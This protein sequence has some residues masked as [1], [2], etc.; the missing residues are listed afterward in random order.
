MRAVVIAEPGGPEKLELREVPSPS[1]YPGAVRVA[2]RT[3]ALNRADVLQRRGFYP[4]PPGVPADIPGLEFAGEVVECGPDARR[5]AVG[6]RVMGLV[7]GGAHAEEVV[8]HERELLAVP[9]VLDDVAAAAVPEAFIT[10]WDALFGQAALRRGETVLIHAVGSGVGT[11]A[12]Q[13]A[14]LCGATSIGTSRTATKLDRAQALGLDHG[15]VCAA[16]VFDDRSVEI[17]RSLSDGRGVDV[18]LDLVGGRYLQ[19]NVRAMAHGARLVTLG[20]LSGARGELDLS[21]VLAR[22][23]RLQGSTLRGRPIEQK[24]QLARDFEREVLPAFATGQL[25]PVVERVVSME[26]VREAHALMERNETFGKIVLR[27]SVTDRDTA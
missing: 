26:E 7:G 22:N 23:L 1:L 10:A 18:V 25:A 2:V 17:V 19:G 11:A 27:W 15:V 14:S 13:L 9:D 12:L 20:L 4:A 6:A 21:V 3:S 16:G 24:I 5:F 8:V